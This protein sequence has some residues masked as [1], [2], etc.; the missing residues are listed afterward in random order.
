MMECYAVRGHVDGRLCGGIPDI[1]LTS[2]LASFGALSDIQSDI[3]PE[4]KAML[5]RMRVVITMVSDRCG[6]GGG[7]E[8]VG[9]GVEK[10]N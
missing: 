3:E 4:R 10:T 1:L 7:D 2:S 9:R 5:V 8:R 6:V